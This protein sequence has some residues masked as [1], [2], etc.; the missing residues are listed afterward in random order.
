M[1]LWGSLD[2]RYGR[3]KALFLTCSHSTW[4]PPT[5]TSLHA[6]TVLWRIAMSRRVTGHGPIVPIRERQRMATMR[7]GYL[8][9]LGLG[10]L[11]AGAMPCAQA[12]GLT[13]AGDLD[14]A[15]GNAGGTITAF[16]SL[17]TA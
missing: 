3:E 1:T 13:S 2:A 15:F 6:A 5:S 12:I 11:L 14:P 8:R 16:D 10:L 17:P 4:R 9:R 7:T